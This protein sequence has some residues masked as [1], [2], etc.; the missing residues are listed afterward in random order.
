MPSPALDSPLLRFSTRVTVAATV[1]RIPAASVPGRG[2]ASA[3]ASATARSA[4]ASGGLGGLCVAHIGAQASVRRLSPVAWF[5]PADPSP[6]ADSAAVRSR[7]APVSE[8]PRAALSWLASPIPALEESA[9]AKARHGS[10]GSGR[11]SPS[12][13]GVLSAST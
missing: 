5:Q 9:S 10:P 7:S 4:A 13:E 6:L 2:G 11:W 8:P 3:R 12:L 1:R